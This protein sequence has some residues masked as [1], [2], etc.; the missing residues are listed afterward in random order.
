MKITI[1][2]SNVNASLTIG[3]RIQIQTTADKSNLKEMKKK[4]EF[5]EFELSEV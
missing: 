1:L 3:T 4:F 5:R 2:T